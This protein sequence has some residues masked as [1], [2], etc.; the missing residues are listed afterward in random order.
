MDKSP[1]SKKEL[2]PLNPMPGDVVSYRYLWYDKENGKLGEKIRPCLIIKAA[3][4]GSSMILVPISTKEDWKAGD[5][6]EIPPEDRKAAGT[7]SEKRSWIKLNEINKVDLPNLGAIPHCDAEGRISWR[8]GRVSDAVL[9]QVTSEI[10]QRVHDK[11]LKGTHI[12]A[13]KQ[14]YLNLAFVR[15]VEPAQESLEDR[16]Q[17]RAAAELAAKAPESPPKTYKQTDKQTDKQ[18]D[19]R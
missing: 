6:I 7:H 5:C 19:Q 15:K 8:R 16:L 11:S 17:R 14:A 12:K 2:D 4:D 10:A 3:N 18:Q 9:K 1:E 13:D